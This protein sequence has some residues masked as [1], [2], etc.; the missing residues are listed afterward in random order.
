MVTGGHSIFNMS[1]IGLTWGA[2]PLHDYVMGVI[3]CASGDPMLNRP[4]IMPPIGVPPVIVTGNVR[5]RASAVAVGKL[6]GVRIPPRGRVTV[7]TVGITPR[8]V[9]EVEGSVMN[10]VPLRK[11]FAM[12]AGASRSAAAAALAFP[13]CTAPANAT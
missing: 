7:E 4:G 5:P 6:S 9:K 3:A 8:I 2:L 12:N 1:L 13:A 11:P 10:V